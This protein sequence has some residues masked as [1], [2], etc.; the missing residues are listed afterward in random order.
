MVYF[1]DSLWFS[2][3]TIWDILLVE[4]R[5]PVGTPLATIFFTKDETV[6]IACSIV[7]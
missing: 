5:Y 4:A 6:S 2:T 1:V 3:R 7:I